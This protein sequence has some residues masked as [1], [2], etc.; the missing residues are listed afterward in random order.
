MSIQTWLGELPKQQFVADYYHKLPFSRAGAAQA[1]CPLG[2][3]GVLDEL[4]RSEAADVL[5]VERGRRRSDGPRSADAARRLVDEGCTV[6]IRHA[7]RHHEPLAKLAAAFHVDFA[8]PVNVHVYVTGGGQ[9][10]FGWHY[11]AEDVFIVQTQGRKQYALRKNTV[12]PWP[13]EETL[14][15]DMRYEREL[16]PL[17]KCLLSPGD[18]LYIPGGYWHMAEAVGEEP[19]ISLAVGVMSR[20]AVDV[21]DRL[22]G[23]LLES[24][25]WRQRVPITGAA[26][27]LAGDELRA[28]YRELLA[29][30]AGDLSNAV[31]AD[32]FLDGLLAQWTPQPHSGE[33]P[34]QDLTSESGELA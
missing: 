26:S 13:L 4:L 18:W 29:Q 16:M 15:E 30:L 19:S 20:T 1:A 11:D 5:V 17:M 8:A 2:S 14:P 34:G 27:P 23:R 3:W 21:F 12:N 32:D 33:E 6:L 24:L 31:Q 7:E 25:L 10:G 28:H 9:F 22:R